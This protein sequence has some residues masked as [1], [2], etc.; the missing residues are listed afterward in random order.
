[1][2]YFVCI[3]VASSII[4]SSVVQLQIRRV[5]RSRLLYRIWPRLIL[6]PSRA[7]VKCEVRGGKMRGTGA[8]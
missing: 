8:R 1:M 7:G 3:S 4:L 2:C 5:R 6:F